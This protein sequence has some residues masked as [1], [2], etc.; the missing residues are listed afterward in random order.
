[1]DFTK[2]K[3]LAPM[4]IEKIKILGVVLEL[5]AKQH[6]QSSLFIAKNG[7]N[8]LNWQCSL[9]GGS[10]TAL[11]ISQCA[12]TDLDKRFLPKPMTTTG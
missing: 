2:G 1:M 5:P 11:R 7:P 8:G 6:C 10:K 3:Y 12:R 9:T 4:T